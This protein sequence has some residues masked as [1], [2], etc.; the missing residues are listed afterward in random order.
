MSLNKTYK[1]WK[2]IIKMAKINF[3]GIGVQKA[4]TSWL[5]KCLNEHPDIYIHPEK[6]AHFFNKGKFYL[7]NYHYESSFN[8]DN[9]KIIGEITPSYISNPKVAKKIFQYNPKVKMIIILRDPTERCISQYKMEMSRGTIESNNGLWDAFIRDLPKYGP[10]KQRGLYKE[11]I[12]RYYK[13]FPV[14]QML[15][16]DYNE[17]GNNPQLFIKKSFEKI[18]A[19]LHLGSFTDHTAL[20][21]SGTI[22]MFF[23]A[24]FSGDFNDNRVLWMLIGITIASTHVDSLERLRIVQNNSVKM[25]NVIE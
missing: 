5:A 8:H 15:I 21:V 4:G 10:M 11:Q 14:K 6:E 9:Q 13:Y 23:A 24:Q 3:I 25:V 20:W 12:E 19:G 2:S 16:L 18:K 22:V 17:I 1:L 7:N